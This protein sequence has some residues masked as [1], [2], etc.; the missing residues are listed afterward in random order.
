MI[1]ILKTL[2]RFKIEIFL[3][4]GPSSLVG[5]WFLMELQTIDPDSPMVLNV[6]ISM[7]KSIIIILINFHNYIIL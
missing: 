5:F 6:F 7:I 3:T 2:H 1:K 4:L